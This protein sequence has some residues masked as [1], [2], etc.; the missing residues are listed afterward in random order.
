MTENTIAI[1]RGAARQCRLLCGAVRRTGSN[2]QRGLRAKIWATY[3]PGQEISKTP[4]A[5]YL[6]VAKQVQE[7]IETYNVELRGRTLADGPA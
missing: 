6:A 3:K 2:C 1:G 7:W 5:E 4:S